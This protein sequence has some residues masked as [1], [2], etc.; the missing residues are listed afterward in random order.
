MRTIKLVTSNDSPFRRA[1]TLEVIEES[2]DESKKQ[3]IGSLK[4][5]HLIPTL[6]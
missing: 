1:T 6:E 2:R 3:V 5:H 4:S